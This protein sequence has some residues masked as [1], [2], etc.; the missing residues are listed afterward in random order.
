[1]A[2]PRTN[3]STDSI[4]QHDNN[5]RPFEAPPHAITRSFAR[6]TSLASTSSSSK[7]VT[8]STSL[9][10]AA[11]TAA[12]AAAVTPRTLINQ[13]PKLHGCTRTTTTYGMTRSNPLTTAAASTLNN[14]STAPQGLSKRSTATNTNHRRKTL[15]SSSLT[16]LSSNETKTTTRRRVSRRLS[17]AEA[18]AMTGM[19]IVRVGPLVQGSATHHPKQQQQQQPTVDQNDENDPYSIAFKPPVLYTTDKSPVKVFAKTSATSPLQPPRLPSTT[20]TWLSP[21]RSSFSQRET[22]PSSA[23]PPNPLAQSTDPLLL[24]SPMRG[25]SGTIAASSSSSAKKRSLNIQDNEDDTIKFNMPTSSKSFLS[26]QPMEVDDQNLPIDD[27]LDCLSP[28]KKKRSLS[29]IKDFVEDAEFD[30]LTKGTGSPTITL[31]SPPPRLP[32]KSSWSATSHQSNG[33]GPVSVAME[34]SPRMQLPASFFDRTTTTSTISGS[35]R[36]HKTHGE[37]QDQTARVSVYVHPDHHVAST[38][39]GET[40][41]FWE[42]LSSPV[43]QA[44]AAA[45]SISRLPQSSTRRKSTTPKAPTSVPMTR[46]AA[47]T[48]P[49]FNSVNPNHQPQQVDQMQTSSQTQMNHENYIENSSTLFN[50]DTAA[51][52]SM[53]DPSLDN[54]SIESFKSDSS[55]EEDG[56]TSVMSNSS[57]A[58]DISRTSTTSSTSSMSSA[59]TEGLARLQTML[60]RLQM[61]RQSLNGGNETVKKSTQSHRKE[62]NAKHDKTVEGRTSMNMQRTLNATS[63]WVGASTSLSTTTTGRTTLSAQR[64]A[65]STIPASS[66]R[67]SSSTSSAAPSNTAARLAARRQSAANA[68]ASLSKSTATI[69]ALA[70]NNSTSLS[71]GVSQQRQNSLIPSNST[72]TLSTSSTSRNS[73]TGSFNTKMNHS[74]PLK[75]V[76]ACVDVRTGE[77]DDAGMLF[78]DMLKSLGAKILMRPSLTMTHLIWKSG[79]PLQNYFGGTNQFDWPNYSTT[80]TSE[81]ETNAE[82]KTNSLFVV[83]IGWVVKCAEMNQKIN[84]KEF[85]INL[86]P[87]KTSLNHQNHFKT[88]NRSKQQQQQQ[89]REETML[90]NRDSTFESNHQIQSQSQ[91]QQQRRRK[92]MEPKA[93]MALGSRDVNRRSSLAVSNNNLTTTNED[94]IVK[95]RVAASLERAR[96]KSLQYTPKV[97]SPLAKRVSSFTIEQV[98]QEDEQGE[99]DAL[100]QD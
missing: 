97:G 5:L 14:R 89:Q 47:M 1:M 7:T 41:N 31:R 42:T 22:S 10:A 19:G 3:N 68:V 29:P 15:D 100:M 72:N 84:E 71:V 73:T 75:G 27:E 46:S 77:G 58:G 45:A 49:W 79:K 51:N 11:T 37:D 60:S 25:F 86:E 50:V 83:G 64:R 18:S 90:K 88:S 95:A 99:Q 30:R 82:T 61:P 36:H 48:L 62:P 33:L 55:N 56:S 8:S 85:L 13:R 39:S 32:S 87:F 6:R 4:D 53:E 57:G 67:T 78:V 91:T 76:V 81:T 23:R 63:N 35:P 20:S 34:R 74:L 21:S 92:S 65:T 40:S 69:A 28:R 12:A 9:T 24:S 93:L 26:Q 80:T 54:I 66:S 43:K 98:L 44:A 52:T 17:R 2:R 16:S 70:N 94:P 38:S 96:K 59:T